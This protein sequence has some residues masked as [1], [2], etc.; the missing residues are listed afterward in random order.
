MNSTCTHMF[1]AVVCHITQDMYG[2]GVLGHLSGLAAESDALAADM[3]RE[4]FQP[5][6]DR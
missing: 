3:R 5:F 4:V 2:D 1:Y 6:W